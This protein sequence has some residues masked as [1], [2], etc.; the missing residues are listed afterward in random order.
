[1][2]KLLLVSTAIAGVALMSA[3]ASAAV[4][5][6][7]GGFF[8]GYGAY[9]D[10][11]EVGFSTTASTA[12]TGAIASAAAA[13]LH[14]FE[15]RRDSELHANGETTLDNGLTIG[16]HSE[17]KVANGSSAFTTD[18]TYGYASGG[19]GRINLGV[20]DGAAYLLQI[21][22]PS[23][24]SNI[25]GIRTNIA[26]KNA[27]FTVANY[28]VG[29]LASD[30]ANSYLA[31]GTGAVV[32]LSGNAGYQQADYRATDR[33]T[34]LTPKFN[35]FQA[36]V[37]YAPKSGITS[38]TGAMSTD[39]GITDVIDLWEASA[40]WDG[41]YQGFGLSVGGGYSDSSLGRTPVQADLANAGTNLGAAGGPIPLQADGLQTWNGGASVSF[42]GFTL[43]GDYVESGTKNMLGIGT[44]GDDN[45]DTVASV[46]YLDVTQ[47]TYVVGL[48]YDNGPY[49]VGGSYLNSN[50]ER[51]ATTGV[52]VAAGGSNDPGASL[53]VDYTTEQ[54]ALGGGYTFGPGMTFRGAVAWGTNDNGLYNNLNNDFTQVT[55]GTD[56]QF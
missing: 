2:K 14:Q 5:L 35:G 53:K 28:G 34:Y 29:L 30:S 20:E 27:S 16:A 32:G 43:G 45:G 13:S 38:Q 17:M 19:W 46:E 11:N 23:A 42:S 4:K 25:D 48:G 47:T 26:A 15:F 10:N 41:E 18:E 6:D 40:R 51:D 39:G 50:T 52:W 3:P 44:S 49:H 37:S 12:T 54:Y 55:V 9:A 7:L 21:A 24:D 36:G 33:L 8:R 22:A 56:V 1:M 31:N